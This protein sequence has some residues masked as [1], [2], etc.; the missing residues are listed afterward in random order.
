MRNI[1]GPLTA[2]KNVEKLLSDIF[3]NDIKE[4]AYIAKKG[5]SVQHYLVKMIHT[6]HTALDNYSSREIFAVVTNVIDWNSAFV[7]Q[8]PKN[9]IQ[10]LQKNWVRN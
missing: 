10:S 6:T 7:R 9:S 4:K 3:I 1:S 2:D 5:P 8:C